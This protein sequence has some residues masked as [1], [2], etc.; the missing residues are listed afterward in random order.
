MDSRKL[1]RSGHL[2]AEQEVD[3]I[4]LKRRGPLEAE[5]EVGARKLNRRKGEAGDWTGDRL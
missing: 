4:K 1:K 3:A 5:R 2:E